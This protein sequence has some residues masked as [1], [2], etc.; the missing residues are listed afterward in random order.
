M[1]IIMLIASLWRH[2]HIEKIIFFLKKSYTT[3]NN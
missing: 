3:H 2:T 1:K